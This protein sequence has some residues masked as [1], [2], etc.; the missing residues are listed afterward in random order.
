MKITCPSCKRRV[1]LKR[2]SKTRCKC[3][4]IHSYNT[5]FRE[6]VNYVVYLVD[7]NI[8]IYAKNKKSKRRRNCEKVLSFESPAIRIGTSDVIMDEIKTNE[9]MILPEHFHI[10]ST[11]KLSPE[12]KDLKTNYLK[13]PSR[14]DLSLVQ[15]AIEHPEIKGII[16][17]DRDF[18]RIATQGVI[19]KKSS[20]KF[21]LGTAADFLQ[22]YEIKSHTKS[23]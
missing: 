15:A 3:G 19:Q 2:G 6:K 5:F 4:Q 20:T 16:T 22:K 1:R 11:G 17:Y 9:E 13:Q 7:A 18:S 8:F 12:L 10:Y 14:A 23:L 21:W